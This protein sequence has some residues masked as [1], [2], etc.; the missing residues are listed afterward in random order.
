VLELQENSVRKANNG[1]Q[2]SS[3]KKR[4]KVNLNNFSIIST[5]MFTLML[6]IVGISQCTIVTKQNTLIEHQASPIFNISL[7]KDS[8]KK[9]ID[10]I[11][12][13][14]GEMATNVEISTTL[15]CE[16]GLLEGGRSS[17]IQRLSKMQFLHQNGINSEYINVDVIPKPVIEKNQTSIITYKNYEY[18][19]K[20]DVYFLSTT[21]MYS[22]YIKL[23]Y[24]NIEGSKIRK[25]YK[26][27]RFND[28]EV[29]PVFAEPI[30]LEDYN[31]GISMGKVAAK[32]FMAL[33]ELMN[34]IRGEN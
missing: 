3:P 9:G 28:E 29:E 12:K 10:L 19:V 15:V 16:A 8:K 17:V 32:D 4:M 22:Y 26:A 1:K 33:K 18:S 2:K 31:K 30:S 5:T 27:L 14:S 7:L 11:V 21:F 24:H 23:Q 6:V 20:S 13:N 34:E 25:Y